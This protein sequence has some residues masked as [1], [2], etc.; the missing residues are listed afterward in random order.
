MSNKYI[1]HGKN[2]VTSSGTATISLMTANF[3]GVVFGIRW[4]LKARQKN[5]LSV[6][7]T[8]T[9][10]IGVQRDNTDPVALSSISSG[11]SVITTGNE[12]DII[13]SGELFTT[14]EE[15]A[16]TG[17]HEHFLYIE[18]KTE[19][20]AKVSRKLMDDDGLNLY[21]HNNAFFGADI[22]Y[23]ITFYYKN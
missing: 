12:K 22:L 7:T 20:H 4:I 18:D 21:L 13:A 10:A 14:Y 16:T 9:W 17:L 1:V 19:G 2:T 8:T 6:T 11:G 23:Q 15:V 3:P 5:H